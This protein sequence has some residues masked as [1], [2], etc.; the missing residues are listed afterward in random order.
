M[1]LNNYC[2][3]VEFNQSQ[4]QMTHS[5]SNKLERIGLWTVPEKP[6]SGFATDFYT[7]IFTGSINKT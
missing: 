2:E 6:H 7:Y 4:E 5:V 3:D 1:S